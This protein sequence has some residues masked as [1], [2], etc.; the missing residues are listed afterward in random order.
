MLRPKLLLKVERTRQSLGIVSQHRDTASGPGLQIVEETKELVPWSK[1]SELGVQRFRFFERPL[2]HRQGGLQ[3]DLRGL[4]GFVPEPQGN[5]RAI[6][7]PLQQVEGV[8][9]S[10]GPSDLAAAQRNIQ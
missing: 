2:L 9:L 10:G 3:I 8:A 6:H 4:H 7:A 5:H 1:A